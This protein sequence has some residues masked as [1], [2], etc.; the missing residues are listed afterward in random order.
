MFPGDPSWDHYFKHILNDIFYFVK[1]A[2]LYNYADDNTLSYSHPD[3]LKTK[4]V[5]TPES[6]YVIE[7]FGT[8]QMQ[9]KLVKF[10]AIVLGK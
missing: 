1:K 8:L 9:A 6:E 5:L 2:N 7:W 4:I 3:T 10:Q